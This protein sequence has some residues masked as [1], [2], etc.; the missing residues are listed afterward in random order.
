MTGTVERATANEPQLVDDETQ[1]RAV[2]RLTEWAQSAKAAYEVASHLVKTSFVPE[3]FR[4]KPHEATAAIL[5][6][7]EVGLSPMS[8]LRAFDVIQ[9]TAAPRAITL[10]AVAQA[11]GHQFALAESTPTR[12]VMKAR[13]RGEP[14]V[15]EVVWTI[16]RAQQLGL[17]NKPNWK[18]QPQAMLVARATAE[19]ARLVASDAILG[20]AGGYASEEIADSPVPLG[21]ATNGADPTP[22][23]VTIEE[24]AEQAT[25]QRKRAKKTQP[26]EP[27]DE[28]WPPP[29]VDET[30]EPVQP[31]IT[32]V[33]TQGR[34]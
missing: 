7:L 22:P 33:D 2:A 31:A 10:R 8:A 20:L 32:D 9:G 4:D 1:S 13:R 29:P 14:D 15:Q 6:G 26:V 11:A 5:A 17:V 30:G 12:C 19:A 28:S 27:V 25:A 3:A 34:T 18:S 21:A 16:E 24:L 23:R